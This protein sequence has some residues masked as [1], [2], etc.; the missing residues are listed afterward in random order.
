MA[1]TRR[2][3]IALCF[4]CAAFAG[5]PASAGVGSAAGCPAAFR[6]VPGV[7]LGGS[8]QLLGV[9]SLSP[10]DAWAVGDYVSEGSETAGLAEHW[11][12]AAWTALP[13]PNPRE[14]NIL[15]A[16]SA[17]ASDDVWAVGDLTLGGIT[18]GLVEHFDGTT[19]SVVPSPNPG[20]DSTV[21]SA[22]AASGSRDVLTA[23]S[24]T[25]AGIQR[26]L[27]ERWNGTAWSVV[28]VQPVPG[29]SIAS[30]AG[31]ARSPGDAWAVGVSG[32]TAA[33]TAPL[34][35]RAARACGR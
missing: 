4:L 23:G 35:E 34:I 29:A 31:I 1:R 18:Y 12:G 19:W 13:A 7:G 26:P 21:L 2:T 20:T 15:N 11:D 27:V 6:I 22:V 9:A 10:T 30:F 25:V 17:V 24:A 8:G 5:A 3:T 16:V 28:S 14:E 33:L 32:A